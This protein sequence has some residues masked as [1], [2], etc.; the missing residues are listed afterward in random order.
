[1]NKFCK[2]LLFN[3]I[4]LS[5][6]THANTYGMLANKLANKQLLSCNPATKR[7]Y[8]VPLNSEKTKELQK[9]LH[10]NIL[11]TIT[12]LINNENVQTKCAAITLLNFLIDQGSLIKETRDS[13]EKQLYFIKKQ[14]EYAI[15]KATALATTEILNPN[16]LNP[17]I[18]N[19]NAEVQVATLKLLHTLVNVTEEDHTFNIAAQAAKR[20]FTSK[21][22]SVK[23]SALNLFDILFGKSC[24][25]KAATEAA[26]IA[27]INE[28]HNTQCFAL[29]FLGNIIERRF[30]Q[31]YGQPYIHCYEL[32]EARAAVSIAMTS[33]NKRVKMAAIK[34][35]NKITTKFNT[36]DETRS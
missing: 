31:C 9:A 8:R 29:K 22:Y 13:V 19:P 25:F 11:S 27:L 34:L 28:D 26:V 33:K 21:N 7:T 35:L 5:L 1:M 4:V 24:G 32:E 2:D 14:Q 16:I 17:N 15:D 18:L 20:A 12:F 10:Y 30:G 6:I 3:V 23:K 36:T